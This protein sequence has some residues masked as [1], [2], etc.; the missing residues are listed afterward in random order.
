MLA[1]LCGQGTEGEKPL[2]SRRRGVVPRRAWLRKGARVLAQG[3][4]VS[5]HLQVAA[6]TYDELCPHG[7]HFSSFVMRTPLGPAKML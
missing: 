1:L 5:Q 2:W 3:A 6:R 7:V 4:R